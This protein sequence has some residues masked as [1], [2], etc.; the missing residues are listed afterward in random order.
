MQLPPLTH[1]AW[2]VY[3]VLALLIGI[4]MIRWANRNKVTPAIRGATVG[5][6]IDAVTGAHGTGRK[7]KKVAGYGVRKS[8]AQLSGITGFVLVA[9]GMLAAIM[10]VYYP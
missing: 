3:G 10:S 9:A 7:S 2:L 8:L 5:A 4:W 1:P 6:A